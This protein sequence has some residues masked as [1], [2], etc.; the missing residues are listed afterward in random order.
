MKFIKTLSLSFI[1]VIAGWWIMLLTLYPYNSNHQILSMFGGI[2]IS[3][4]GLVD[5]YDE[6]HVDVHDR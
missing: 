2:M 6:F 4:A 5:L 3:I 1:V